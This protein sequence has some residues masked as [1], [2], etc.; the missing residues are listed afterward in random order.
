MQVAASTTVGS[1]ARRSATRPHPPQTAPNQTNGQG[2]QVDAMD[3]SRTHLSTMRFRDAP[4]SNASKAGIKHEF[5]TD[6]QEATLK[7]GLSGID[8]LVQA[9]TG[10]GKT[11]AFLLP[12]IERLEK[13]NLPQDKI[14]ILVISPT[15]ELALQIEKEARDLIAHRQLCVQNAIGG[16]NINKEKSRI[17]SQRCDILVATPGRLIDHLQSNNLKPRLSNLQ[18]LI[19]DEADR[20]LDQGFKRDLETIFSFLPDRRHVPRQC[21]LYSATLSQEIKQI[22]S[23]YLHSNHKFVST[24]TEGETNTHKHAAQFYAIAPMSDIH[25]ATISILLS[26][27]AA[28]PGSSKTIIFCTTARATAFAAEVARQAGGSQMPQVF[29]IHSRMSQNARIKSADAFKS[30]TSAVLFSSDVTARGMDFP[31]VTLVLQVGLP[32]SAEQY[33]H[34]LGRTARA[35]AG[36]RGILLLSPPETYFLAKREM[37]ALPITPYTST[38]SL[39]ELRTVTN[40][41]TTGLDPKIKGQTYAAWLGFYKSYCKPMKWS[42]AQLVI[43]ANKYAREVLGWEGKL[44][45]PLARRTVGMMGLKGVPGLNIVAKLED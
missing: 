6:V 16:T 19:L 15:R 27:A 37:S 34:R 31:G 17:F 13:Q 39:D 28:H 4:I 32:S 2:G 5:L 38:L 30:A 10:T 29:E 36:G 24:L 14:S 40:T 9:K 42:P 41:V 25:P 45:P 18:T 23:L 1:K 22:A 3:T 20:L 44:P 11:V 7:L 35:G 21:M 12:A 33:I 43:E 26:D 8:L